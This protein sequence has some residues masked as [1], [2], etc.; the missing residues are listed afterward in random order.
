MNHEPYSRGFSLIEMLIVIGI[1]ALLVGIG[2]NSFVSARNSKQLDVTLQ[3]VASKLYEAK[4]SA[5]SGKNGQNFGVKFNSSS[6]VYFVGSSFNPSDSA[7]V[8]FQIPSNINMTYTLPGPDYAVIFSR[9][10]GKPQVSGNITLTRT[11][12][13]SSTQ[14][15]VIG[16]LGDISVI[17]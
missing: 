10:T 1:I 2:V 12:N 16:T 9:M 8:T 4:S 14:T 7:N 17:K 6:Y 15:I 13:A 3:A 11:D 5:I